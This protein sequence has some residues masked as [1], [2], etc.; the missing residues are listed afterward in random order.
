MNDCSIRV[1][2]SLGLPPSKK[3][4]GWMKGF[5]SYGPP[6]TTF[7]CNSFAPQGAYVMFTCSCTVKT[8]W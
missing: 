1:N 3:E 4:V 8:S 6:F 5:G 2:Q 7:I